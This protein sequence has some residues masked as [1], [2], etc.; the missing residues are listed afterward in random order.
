MKEQKKHNQLYA[1]TINEMQSWY[2]DDLRIG[3]LKSLEYENNKTEAKGSFFNAFRKFEKQE[4]EIFSDSY[5]DNVYYE[6]YKTYV[7]EKTIS[8]GKKIQE[9]ENLIEYE[10]FFLRFERKMSSETNNCGNYGSNP[11]T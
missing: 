6:K 7:E 1:P 4:C 5:K 11:A 8:M 10:K 9:I 2:E 3:A